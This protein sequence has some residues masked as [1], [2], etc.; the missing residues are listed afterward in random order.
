VTGAAVPGELSAIEAYWIGHQ[1]TKGMYAVDGG[2]TAELA[3]VMQ[4][5]RAAQQGVKAGGFDLTDR[6]P[7]ALLASGEGF[8]FTI[9]QQPYLQ[10]FLPILQLFLWQGL[11]IPVGSGGSE[12]GPE[13]PRQGKHHPVRQ[14]QEPLRGHLL[15]SQSGADRG[16]HPG[17]G[18]GT[19][20]G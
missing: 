12:H 18:N 4:K 9:D 16:W 3:G 5:L 2:S 13:V 20:G 17:V 8:E 7:E 1:N 11:R 19:G 10:G 14:L 6:D 15:R